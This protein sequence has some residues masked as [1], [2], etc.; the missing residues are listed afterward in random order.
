[1]LDIE[2]RKMIFVLWGSF[3]GTILLSLRV[4]MNL[5]RLKHG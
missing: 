1:M 4:S 3:R 5:T 2:L